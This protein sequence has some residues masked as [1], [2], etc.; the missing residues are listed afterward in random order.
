MYHYSFSPLFTNHSFFHFWFSSSPASLKDFFCTVT[1]IPRGQI[2]SLELLG[3]PDSASFPAESALVLRYRL[4][5]QPSAAL[6]VFFSSARL[7]KVSHFMPAHLSDDSPRQTFLFIS[8]K[9]PFLSLPCYYSECLLGNASLLRILSPGDVF[10]SFVPG[11]RNDSLTFWCSLFLLGS[12]SD[13]SSLSR[14]FPQK[15]EVL[16]SLQT[17]LSLFPGLLI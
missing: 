7:P 14:N 10:H 16:H 6:S 4:D 1:G 12:P 15:K 2:L 17:A 5:Q 9:L 11:L 3:F 8:P 13:I